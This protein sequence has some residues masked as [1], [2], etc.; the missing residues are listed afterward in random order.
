MKSS[1]VLVPVMT[2]RPPIRFSVLAVLALLCLATASARAAD[3]VLVEAESFK[4]H[5]G[6]SLDTQFI[7]IMGSPYLLAHGL[8][9]PVKDAATAVKFPSTGKYR[10]L[11]R[12]KDWV[13]RWKAAGQPGKFQLLIDGQPLTETFGTKGAEWFWH[14]G[15]TVEIS[16]PQVT[17]ALRDLTGFDGRC[18]AILFT[19]DA[20]FVPPND[21]TALPSWRRKLLGG[22]E[23]I[24]EAGPYD[25][26]VVGGGYSG[27]GTAISAARMGCKV[28]LIQNRPV[29]GGNGSSEI[30]VWAMGGT[31]RGLYPNLGE[32]VE[33]FMD[34]AKA[35]PGTFEEFGDEKKE[36]VVRAE[37]NISLHLNTH[38][39]SVELSPDKK[40]IVSI[41]G[42]NTM[43]G[44]A[45][46]FK[47]VLFADCT[48][49]ATIGALA[50]ADHTTKEEGH[51]GMSNMWR[52][53]DTGKPQK[54]PA[55]PWALDMTMEDFPYPRRGLGE[56]FWESGFD[57][58]PLH[59][60]EYTRDWNLRAVYGAFHTMKNKDG[61][62]D[63]PNAK[64]VWVAYIGGTR[65]SR[66]LLGDVILTRD[67][68]S[69]KK[70][71]P[72][73]CVPTTWDID[74]HYPKEQY[75]KKFPEN[76]FI[77]KAVFDKAVD[78][79]HGY[80]VPY[81]CFYSRNI[82]NLFMAGRCIS[83]THEALGTVRVMKTGGM[84][85]EVVGK[86]ASLC[87]KYNCTPRDVYHNYFNELKE[88][89]NLKGVTRRDTVT[90][91]FYT[92]ANAAQL[93]PPEVTFLDPAK[94]PG[95]V[96]DDDKAKVSGKWTAGE[97]LKGYV[98]KHYLYAGKG[99]PASI[100]YEFT[101]PKTGN[102]EVRVSYG[103]H[104]NRASNTP[105]VIRS[106]E[107][108][109]TVRINQKKAPPLE[110]GFISVGTY[111]FEAGKPA[112]VAITNDG[113]DGNAHADAV[114]LLPAP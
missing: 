61:A 85:G 112:A 96:V 54:F 100:T 40:R 70:S 30:R 99:A 3:T 51:L 35:S 47:G 103:M 22:S 31:R 16:K 13:A 94:L 68:I 71:F 82:E 14:D 27:M 37:K 44:E 92:A 59:D 48:G 2:L 62:K 84:I 26:V 8:G 50:G 79:N 64:L 43:T 42:F 39:F 83:V 97:G 86:A 108:E 74:L 63:H 6:W 46:R 60:L 67:D 72:D 4:D 109:K 93:P 52:W 18:D 107:G 75:A 5:G 20:S 53:E 19:K 111:R 91:P 21:V 7:E 11:V 9:E 95:I 77:S 32:I 23:R 78:R 15:G 98:G 102:Y 69:T 58:H 41:T 24:T 10:V 25:V 49:H 101:V 17:L 56:W 105:V 104:E 1:R 73:G 87:L 55:T 45:T 65:E 114:Q 29:L 34:R 106:A 88:L 12:T 89:M 57:K 113:V 38:A 66:Q 76:P 80:P 36:A 33:E 28:A 90:G 110:K 81:R